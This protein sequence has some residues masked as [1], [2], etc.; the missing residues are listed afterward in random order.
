MYSWEY[1]EA[2]FAS[3]LSYKAKL[4]GLAISYYYNWKESSPSFPSVETLTAR[5]SLSRATIHRAKLELVSQGY[6][7]Q[8]RKYDQS[9][10]YIPQIPG[11]SQTD[12][13][14]VSEGRTNNEVNY[15]VN[16]VV[17]ESSFQS[18]SNPV[19]LKDIITEEIKEIED[20]PAAWN[21]EQRR[22]WFL[23]QDFGSNRDSGQINKVSTGDNRYSKAIPGFL[24]ELAEAGKEE[25]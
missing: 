8:H 5:T 19:I 24:Q 1:Q 16:N 4:V 7:V 6:L 3:N 17:L 18:D 22:A 21:E 20:D 13:S 25:W 23:S 2:I 9:N 11:M 12:T 10:R 15:E 14:L